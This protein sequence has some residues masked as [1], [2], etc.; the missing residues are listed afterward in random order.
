MDKK[1]I[2]KADLQD[3]VNQ[4]SKKPPE[5]S[6][7]P[8]EIDEPTAKNFKSEIGNEINNKRKYEIIDETPKETQ[9]KDI[10]DFKRQMTKSGDNYHDRFANMTENE[11]K[12]YCQGLVKHYKE[13]S[14]KAFSTFEE[15]KGVV[16]DQNTY[17]REIQGMI[18]ARME[19]P[20]SD[21]K[22]IIDNLKQEYNQWIEHLFIGEDTFKKEIG[23][24]N[25]NTIKM[26]INSLE[27]QMKSMPLPK[28]NEDFVK[29]NSILD[30]SSIIRISHFNKKAEIY[31]K[32]SETQN[33]VIDG[34]TLIQDTLD[35]LPEEAANMQHTISQ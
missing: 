30:A 19:N 10:A 2:T 22:S 35:P 13:K 14:H 29:L 20:S 9:N 4:V 25:K 23:I 15:I 8:N 17:I 28:T 27:E 7:K 26:D 12:E 18:E 1:E 11:R 16:A 32:Y 34:L 3:I 31:D 6:P 21:E 5:I 33:K 24:I